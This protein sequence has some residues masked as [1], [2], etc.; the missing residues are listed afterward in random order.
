MA[1]RAYD[2]VISQAPVVFRQTDIAR[3]SLASE[4]NPYKK[5]ILPLIQFMKNVLPSVEGYD[6]IDQR[7]VFEGGPS[8]IF[9]EVVTFTSQGGTRYMFSPAGG[10]AAYAIDGENEWTFDNLITPDPNSEAPTRFHLRSR[11]YIYYPGDNLYR[12]AGSNFI[13]VVPGGLTLSGVRGFTSANSYMIAYDEQT[14]YYTSS[15]DAAGTP[16]FVP[17]LGVAG[18]TRVLQ[19]RGNINFCV[20]IANGFMIYATENV[21]SAQYSGN[22]A[23]PFTY[24]EV[25]GSMGVQKLNDVA[26]DSNLGSHFAWTKNGFQELQVQKAQEIFPEL[27]Q[28]FRDGLVEDFNPEQGFSEEI[29]GNA[30]IDY[31]GEETFVGPATGFEFKGAVD[32]VALV[33]NLKLKLVAN[34]YLTISYGSADNGPYHWAWIFDLH[35]K[36]W[37]RLKGLHADIFAYDFGPKLDYLTWTELG[38]DTWTDLGSASWNELVDEIPEPE[39]YNFHLAFL[40]PNGQITLLERSDVTDSRIVGGEDKGYVNDSSIVL[41]RIVQENTKGINVQ[42]IEL[43]KIG[44]EST[45]TVYYSRTNS[46]KQYDLLKDI[47]PRFRGDEVGRFDMRVTARHMS[48]SLNGRFNLVNSYVHCTPASSRIAVGSQVNDGI[49]YPFY[50]IPIIEIVEEEGGEG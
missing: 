44:Y 16:N 28:F 7:V 24:R 19:I 35:L 47:V 36:K 1:L 5:E 14:I 8:S 31:G 3:R 49:Q 27:T 26:Y 4:T 38:T 30:G 12:F 29:S 17:A 10:A 25:T 40:A 11:F 46:T 9:D 50:Q 2:L 43:Q 33:Q 20:P 45:A 23:A 41:G 42:Q 22:P 18:S 6:S 39:D 34:R 21:V 48:M 13:V 32:R 15:L 37:G